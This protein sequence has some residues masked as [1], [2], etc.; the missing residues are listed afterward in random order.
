V[1]LLTALLATEIKQLSTAPLVGVTH[2]SIGVLAPGA[3]DMDVPDVFTLK[4]AEPQPVMLV[5]LSVL[6]P[7][8]TR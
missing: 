8:L 6:Q 2:T 3:T 1:G 7:E 4:G 5:M